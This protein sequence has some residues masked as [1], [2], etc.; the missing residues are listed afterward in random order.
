MTRKEEIEAAETENFERTR[1]TDPK[2]DPVDSNGQ[3]V[4]VPVV[5]DNK[6]SRVSNM[7][8]P[9]RSIIK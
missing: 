9:R 3:S 1:R 5:G 8:S 2:A 7:L 6:G 4:G